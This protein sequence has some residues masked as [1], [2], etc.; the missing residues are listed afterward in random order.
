MD[1]E[2]L[3]LDP[4]SVQDRITSRTRA[5]LAVH[6]SGLAADLDSLMAVGRERGIPVVEDCAQAYGCE[7]QGRLT[8]TFTGISSFSLNHFK[9]ITCG[10]GG[11]VLTD[12]DHLRYVASL[13]LDK[14]YQR[15]EKI[16]NPF[17]LAPNYQMTELQGAV[18]RA[19][20]TRVEEIVNRR[21]DLGSRLSALVSAF[22]V[23]FRRRLR[24]APGTVTFCS[25]S[26]SIWS[27]WDAPR[28]NSRRLCAPRGFLTIRTRS[29]AAGP[30]IS[31]ISSGTAPR[32]R[33]AIIR[34]P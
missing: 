27:G 31:T 9:H 28:G 10:S 7:Y 14:C 33:E 20:L 21:N 30:S 13:F 19:Q 22:R 1:P 29:R 5:I 6:H 24:T 23:S 32:F 2:T 11:M 15:E 3:N 12:D 18:A 16:R 4:R 26:A 25:S 34:S 8:G 17:F